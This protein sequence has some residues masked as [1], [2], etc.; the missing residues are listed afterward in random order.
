ME[1][2]LIFISMLG[3]GLLAWV[4]QPDEV[5]A[6]WLARGYIALVL[7]LTAAAWVYYFATVPKTFFNNILGGIISSGKYPA[8]ILLGYLVATLFLAIRKLE[9]ERSLKKLIRLTITGVSLATG[10]S[11]LIATEGKLASM[12]DMIFFFKQSGYTTGFLYFIMVM[13]T[14]G[15]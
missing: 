7:V 13:E 11:F 15:A 14:L 4:Y 12:G 2:I 1:M 6:A 3:G 8:R 5:L 9:N 10:L